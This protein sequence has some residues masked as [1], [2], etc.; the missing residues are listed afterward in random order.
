M[1]EPGGVRLTD[2]TAASKPPSQW[3]PDVYV[4]PFIPQA[5]LAI[6]QCP[7]TPITTPGVDG[8]DFE[9]YIATFYGASFRTP[10]AIP[11]LPISHRLKSIDLLDHP[12]VHRYEEHFQTS[13]LLELE[14]QMQDIRS[15]DL[16]GATLECRDPVNNVFTLSVPGLREDSPLVN[17]GDTV[18]LRQWVEQFAWPMQLS[19]YGWFAMGPDRPGF[20][21]YAIRAVVVGVDKMA[22]ILHIRAFGLV[23]TPHVR[24][25]VAFI[26]Q[27]RVTQSFQVAVTDIA[28]ELQE[29]IMAYGSDAEIRE[30]PSRSTELG[31]T[32]S[33]SQ[34]RPILHSEINWL[35]H[36]LF[37]KQEDGILQEG[38]PSANFPQDWYD[39]TLNYEQK[40]T[41]DAVTTTNYGQLCYLINGPPGTGKTK[42]ICE[43]VT[44]LGK[45]ADFTES[46]LLCAPSNQA[47]DTLAQRLTKHFPPSEMLRLNHFSRTFAEVPIELMLYCFVDENIFDIPPVAKLMAYKIVIATCQDA[48]ILVHSRVSN[49]DLFNLQRSMTTTLF[50]CHEFAL[51]TTPLHWSALIIDEAAQATE[52]ETLIPLSVVTPPSNIPQ[53]TI[54]PIV[55]MAGD[56]H[57]LGPRSYDKSTTLHVSLFER[58]SNSPVYASH[59]L[60]RRSMRSSSS[61]HNTPM[62]RPPFTNLTRNYRSHPAILAVPSSLFYTNTLI[63][64][65]I[66][67]HT[68]SQWPSW[69]RSPHDWP[70][71]FRCNAGRDECE[72]IRD[73]AHGWYNVTEAHHAIACAQDFLHTLNPRPGLPQRDICIMSPFRAQ[74]RLLRRLARDRNLHAINIGP[75]EAFQGLESPVVIICTT[76]ARTRFLADDRARGTGLVGE[77]RKFNVALT[78]A[79]E[80][81]VVIGNPWVLGT[82][83]CWMA[84]LRFCWRN[85]LWVGDDDDAAGVADGPEEG[86][87]KVNDWTPPEGEEEGVDGDKERVVVEPLGLEAAL[88]FKEKE[89]WRGSKAA[90][91]F[92]GRGGEDEQWRS[93]MEAE[94]VVR[95]LDEL[96]LGSANANADDGEVEGGSDAE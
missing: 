33:I 68:V 39:P 17:Y 92:L 20:T 16:Y 62:L 89:Q 81:L 25:N 54:Q 53:D 49:R 70:V 59:P 29:A 4:Q 21:G 48:D 18:M 90:K 61:K 45:H 57:Q 52:P 58:L 78:R 1:V 7:A 91:R 32:G 42:T 13:L 40:K 34:S 46:M 5:I 12:D 15:F 56:Q 44:Q 30:V 63:P 3:R 64:E 24:C 11:S 73:A 23:R 88:L 65:A 14:A 83:P 77:P 35:R 10:L 84:F 2:T 26:K 9:K 94:E 51:P 60:A 43:I 66:D 76:R 38:L 93:G 85:G 37:P 82:D 8:V 41:V 69:S 36:M 86:G 75:L 6:N 19:P 47:A 55:V 28:R 67:S 96:D 79:M 72:S 22:D 87:Q 95:G 71:Q 50:P 31:S 27:T 80:G 74:V